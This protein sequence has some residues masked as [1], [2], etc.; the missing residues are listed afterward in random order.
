[1]M[2]TIMRDMGFIISAFILYQMLLQKGKIMLHEAIA[3][4]L[5]VIIYVIVIVQMS[6]MQ[7]QDPRIIGNSLG[8]PT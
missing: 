5:I 8:K 2:A 4:F 7:S 3:L 6:Q 1:M